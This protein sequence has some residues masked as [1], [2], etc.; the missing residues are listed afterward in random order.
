M[1][2]KT[3]HDGRRHDTSREYIQMYTSA[4]TSKLTH[5]I[6]VLSHHIVAGTRPIRVNTHK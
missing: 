3:S 6:R 2:G 5:K 1:A 4:N